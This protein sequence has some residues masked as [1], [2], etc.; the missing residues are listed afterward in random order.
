MLQ[1][2]TEKRL[3][4]A[5]LGPVRLWAY[6]TGGFASQFGQTIIAAYF[7][8]LLEHHFQAGPAR[9]GLVMGVASAA[10]LL[11]KPAV[12]I[13]SDRS[14]SRWGRRLPYI[15]MATLAV[16]LAFLLVAVSQR[17][18]PTVIGAVL[19]AAG[20]TVFFAP[21]LASLS[22]VIPPEQRTSAT[23]IQTALRGAALLIACTLGA[24]L[25][26]V[27]PGAPFALAAGMYGACGVLTALSLRGS[28]TAGRPHGERVA[29][30]PYLRRTPALRRLLAAHF[31]WWSALQ[32]LFAFIVL[33]VVHDVLHVERIRNSGGQTAVMQAMLLLGIFAATT[34]VA[35]LPV[36]HLA[37]R[38]GRRPVLMGG[39]LILAAGLASTGFATRMAEGC[40]TTVLCGIGYA[41]I[42]VIPYTLIVELRPDGHEGA[43]AALYD[44]LAELPQAIFVPLVGLLIQAVHSYRVIFA[45]GVIM[46]AAALVLLRRQPERSGAPN[47]AGGL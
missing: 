47:A 26:Q 46:V 12:S 21:Y 7:P 18:L 17:F 38:F 30:W 31:C 37:K 45:F 34:M 25:F 13:A 24:W 16:T 9:I 29:L 32:V 36:S 33:F 28:R 3:Y 23:G 44:A 20:S 14:R 35:A 42:Q 2:E 41:A 11:A 27:S 5:P 1:Q 8:A 22:E 43:L 19:Y 15:V 4:P 6:A 39:L 10:S 40:I